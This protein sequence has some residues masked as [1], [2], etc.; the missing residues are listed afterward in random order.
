MGVER[1][2]IVLEGR[3]RLTKV[4][5][6]V[7]QDLAY[8]PRMS[9]RFLTRRRAWNPRRTVPLIAALLATVLIADVLVLAELTGRDEP[10]KAAFREQV[11]PS[12][13][14]T[15]GFVAASGPAMAPLA[16]AP[17]KKLI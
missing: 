8:S 15:G 5:S 7:R 16:V 10:D 9:R 2:E 14:D 12:P 17:L 4:L 6:E 13:P 11:Q 3:A 1:G